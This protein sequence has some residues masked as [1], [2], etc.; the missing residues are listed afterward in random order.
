MECVGVGG[1]GQKARE[2]ARDGRGEKNVR[3]WRIGQ[4]PTWGKHQGLIK[5]I[6]MKAIKQDWE[7]KKERAWGFYQVFEIIT[8]L[9]TERQGEESNMHTPDWTE[10]SCSLAE[11]GWGWGVDSYQDAGERGK[12]NW[13]KFQVF[14]TNILLLLRY[15]SSVI[16]C[17]FQ[18]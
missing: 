7:R 2:T 6:I 9:G 10:G 1:R 4:K 8:M 15:S 12:R 14:D 13:G 18:G 17:S 11:K 3:K 16:T 5:C